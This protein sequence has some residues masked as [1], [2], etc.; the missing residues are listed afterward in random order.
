MV[1]L[2][3]H[4]GGEPALHHLEQVFDDSILTDPLLAPL[5]GA[6]QPAHVDRLTACTAESFGG[7]DR[8]SRQ[9]GFAHLIAV[10]RGLKIIEPQRTSRPC[11]TRLSFRPSAGASPA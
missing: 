10:H 11:R 5:L 2:F 6:G 9:L 8:F 1:T 7:P 4:A 3:E